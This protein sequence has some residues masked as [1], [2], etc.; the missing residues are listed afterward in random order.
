[1]L[2]TICCLLL[3]VVGKFL[4]LLLQPLDMGVLE[5]H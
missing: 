4:F 3:V 2:L 1:M 5:L